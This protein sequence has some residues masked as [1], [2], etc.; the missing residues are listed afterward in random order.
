MSPE[1]MIE[2]EYCR[3]CKDDAR[4]CLH[5]PGR[6][7]DGKMCSTIPQH[8]QILSV[9]MVT[10]PQDPRCRVWPWQM[11]DNKEFHATV[12]TLFKIDD[13]LHTQRRPDKLKS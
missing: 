10:I 13:W 9:S 6:L 5:I 12:M 1:I 2:K 4:A 11:K 8:P 7:Y 3:I